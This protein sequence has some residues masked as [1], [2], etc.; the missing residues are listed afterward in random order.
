MNLFKRGNAKIHS[1]TGITCLP[2]SVCKS[3]CPGCYA[4][5]A[6]LRFKSVLPARQ[7]Q[8]EQ[9]FKTDFVVSMVEQISIAANKNRIEFF[10]IHESGDFYSQNYVDDWAQIV[11][12]CPSIRFYTYTKTTFDFSELEELDNFNLIRSITR[13]GI[14]YG[15]ADYCSKLI[16][17]GFTLCPCVPGWPGKC[18][19]DCTLC[20]VKGNNKICFLKH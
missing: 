5:K 11:K 19:K 9:T 18:M 20:A 2:T 3:L 7:R 17:E 1:N 13:H 16:A 12:D 6:E 10:R 8:L 4:R 14:N 15:G